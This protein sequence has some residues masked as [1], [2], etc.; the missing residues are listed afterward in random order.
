MRYLILLF[1]LALPVQADTRIT[2]LGYS[3][4]F[5]ESDFSYL[6]NQ[7]FNQ[8]HRTFII[9]HASYFVGHY[10]NSYYEDTFVVGQSFYPYQT[11]H[12]RL[13]IR[14]GMSYGYRDCF[15]SGVFDATKEKLFCPA[16]VPEITY[17]GS[18]IYPTL[19]LVG[20]AIAISFDYEF[21]E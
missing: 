5:V 16:V 17:T 6:K 3:H 2:F 7:E 14:A 9:E 10:D 11:K 8:V 1:V 19:S 13:G 4:H 21:G 15:K 18:T 12:F 20:E